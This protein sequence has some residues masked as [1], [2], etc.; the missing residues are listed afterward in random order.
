M[1]GSRRAEA[2][3]AAAGAH[4]SPARVLGR[5]R[6]PPAATLGDLVQDEAALYFSVDE[7]R[8]VAQIMKI[9]KE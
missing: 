5:G 4:P 1:R 6:R 3:Q 7:G 8:G 2:L 9:E